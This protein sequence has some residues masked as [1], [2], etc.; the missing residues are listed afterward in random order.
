MATAELYRSILYMPGSNERALEKAKGLECD[1][2]IFD[3]EDAVTPDKK[4]HARKL[5]RDFVSLNKDAYGT[6]KIF[7]RVNAWDTSWG[8]DDF[9]FAAQ[10]EPDVIL[11]PKINTGNDFKKYFGMLNEPLNPKIQI[12]AMV[13][14]P[15]AIINLNEI[16]GATENLG[17][18]VLGTNDLAKD[19]NITNENSRQALLAALSMTNMVAKANNIVCLDGVYNAFRDIDGLRLECEQGKSFGF[20]GKTLIHPCQIDTT[21]AIFS[22]SEQ[23][24]ETAKSYVEAFLTAQN[25]GS[26]VAVVNGKIVENLHVEM[27]KNT[28]HKVELIE[29]KKM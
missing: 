15:S 6:K 29:K 13:E 25:S 4:S 11:L 8:K 22:P 10:A 27:A 19:L 5:V 24:I 23:D 7:I 26:G 17:G 2:V 12:W 3:L 21:N 18:F 28:L 20:D 9:C 14:T 16:A 1:G